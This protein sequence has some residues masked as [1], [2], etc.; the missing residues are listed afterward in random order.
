MIELVDRDIKIIIIKMVFYMLKMLEKK[1]N[2]LCGD[3]RDI[4]IPKSNVQK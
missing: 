2:M 1:I 3:M 4:K